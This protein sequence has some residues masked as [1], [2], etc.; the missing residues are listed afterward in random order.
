MKSIIFG[1]NLQLNNMINLFR[2]RLPFE[3][4]ISDSLKEAYKV[5]RGN[6]LKGNYKN[7]EK[8]ALTCIL[9]LEWV[10]VFRFI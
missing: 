10:A 9:K 4:E 7:D 5:L 1:L 6:V 3:V 2:K 8:V